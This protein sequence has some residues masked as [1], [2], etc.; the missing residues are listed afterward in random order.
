MTART[1]SARSSGVA[2]A[3][4]SAQ[5]AGR[6]R[7][8]VGSGRPPQ[9]S[10]SAEL[11]AIAAARLGEAPQPLVVERFVDATPTRLPIANRR[12]TSP[13]VSATFW[14]ISLF[15][16]RV[17]CALVGRDEGLDLG[18]ALRREAEDALGEAECRPASAVR[19]VATPRS[20]LADA[21]LDVPE[22]GPGAG[23]ADDRALAGLAL[24]AV[25]RAEHHVARFVADRVA[26][27]PELVGDARCTS[28]S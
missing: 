5:P 26:G 10:S 4:V 21:H 19:L 25:R 15:A 18:G 8:G 27:S 11:R 6:S 1:P 2:P 20:P 23:V 28:G 3:V 22:P 24:A 16:N 7:I 13:F 17:S 14:W 12:L 9:S